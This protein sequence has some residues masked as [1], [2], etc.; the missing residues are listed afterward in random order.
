M[1]VHFPFDAA[2]ASAS[3]I[4]ARLY[5]DPVYLEL[6]RER[7]FGRT[8]QL[9][10]R[11]EQVAQTGQFFTADIAGE[12]IVVLRDGEMLRGFHN[13]CLHRAGPVASG[14]GKRQTMQCRYHGWTYNLRG[15]LIRA[16]EMEGV[17]R[18]TL[19][20][21]HLKPVQVAAWGPL[22]FANLDLKAPP[23]S[24]FLEDIPER[25]TRFDVDAMR[26]VMRKDYVLDCNWKVYVDN[27]LEGYHIP[28]VHPGLHKELDYDEY[29]VEP[30]RYYSLQ[31]APLRPVT[32]NGASRNYV[33]SEQ[34][35][36]GDDAPQYYW[37]FP[38]IMLNVYAGQMQTNVILPL[39]HDRTLTIFEWY[40]THPPANP[41]ADTS[42]TRLLAFSDEIQAE[43]I[44]ICEAVQKNLRSRVYDRGRYSV[45]REN[46]VHH[47]HSLL[48]EFMT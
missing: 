36:A 45:K 1:P 16:P 34:K 48:H 22:V 5:T 10:G 13:V 4:P 41:E 8:W 12:G 7:V 14:C 19:A 33:P 38:N 40:A 21:M 26:Y 31:H 3:T 42:W 20:D 39:S 9:V 17:E 30:H 46:G 15:E 35:S 44:E 24:E 6:E 23:L 32:G 11:A 18:F 2:I 43:A 37:L 29:S 47:F 28:V 27:Y 25:A